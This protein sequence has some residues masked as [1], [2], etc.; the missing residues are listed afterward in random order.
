MYYTITPGEC[1]PHVG[2]II[3][4]TTQKIGTGF[5]VEK[6]FV[7]T[8]LHVLKDAARIS[9]SLDRKRY[10]ADIVDIFCDHDL[11]LLQ[12]EEGYDCSLPPL[13]VGILSRLDNAIKYVTYGCGRMDD[14]TPTF[15]DGMIEALLRRNLVQLKT[16]DQ[17]EGMSGCPL[18]VKFEGQW[19]V[20]ATGNMEHVPE[21][22]HHVPDLAFG[23]KLP[24]QPLP[25]ALFDYITPPVEIKESPANQHMVNAVDRLVKKRTDSL[26]IFRLVLALVTTLLLALFCIGL[27]SETLTL[28]LMIPF[29]VVLGIS[30]IMGLKV[31]KE[32]YISAHAGVFLR[33]FDT[34]KTVPGELAKKVKQF[35][36][37]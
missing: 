31:E 25:L 11:A 21:Y 34:Q 13:P 20:V 17:R 19:Y 24:I 32:N 15:G 33:S 23:F 29:V 35:I 28:S 12:L 9:F 4:E 5:I 22:A 30:F 8:A 10:E 26:L 7:L 1:W 27:I 36:K 14:D 6:N 2:L 18:A 3:N 16:M 37:S